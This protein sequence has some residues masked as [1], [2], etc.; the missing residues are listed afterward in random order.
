MEGRATPSRG[1]CFLFKADEQS[2]RTNKVH[3]ATNLKGWRHSHPE[4]INDSTK[5]V[6]YLGRAI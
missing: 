4:E 3:I 2:S 5:T 6:K 1:Y